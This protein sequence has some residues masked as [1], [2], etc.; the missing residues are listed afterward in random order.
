MARRFV[1]KGVDRLDGGIEAFQEW[2]QLPKKRSPASVRA[3]LRVVR[4]N[5]RTPNSSSSAR[6]VWLNVAFE[7]PSRPAA[8][9]KLV[10]SATATKAL[11]SANLL[12]RIF[13]SVNQKRTP[14]SQPTLGTRSA[15]AFAPSRHVVFAGE[16]ARGGD[17]ADGL[18]F[19]PITPTENAT[20]TV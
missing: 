3:T 13:K 14:G 19:A 10:C 9:L 4:F 6:T 18:H 16:R 20:Q 11:S 5:S 8:L 7:T 17:A 2:S 15:V 1:A 12:R